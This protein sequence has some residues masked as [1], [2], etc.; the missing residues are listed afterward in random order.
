MKPDRRFRP[1]CAILTAGVAL[2]LLPGGGS[3]R[4]WG[5]PVAAVSR[6]PS[7]SSGVSAITVDAVVLD[8]AGVPVRGLTRDDFVV[9]EDGHPQT[10]VG[11]EAR[12]LEKRARRQARRRPRSR[13]WPRTWTPPRGAAGCSCCSSTTSAWT[14]PTAQQVKTALVQ[15][16]GTS[17]RPDDEVTIL[18]TSGDV[19]WADT[20]GAGRKDLLAVTDRIRGKRELPRSGFTTDEEAALIVDASRSAAWATAWRIARRLRSVRP[21][22]RARSLPARAL[23]FSAA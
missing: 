7:F 8:K 15:W 19:W 4:P 3:R 18:T 13:P 1:L 11:F 20:L 2:A 12:A 6:A 21:P 9:L 5:L 17:G 10:I 22:G 14:P 16:L 23:P